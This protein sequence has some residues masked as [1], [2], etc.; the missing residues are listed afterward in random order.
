MRRVHRISLLLIGL[1]LSIGATGGAWAGDEGKIH[2]CAGAGRWFPAD[3]KELR[4]KVN[5]WLDAAQTP[6]VEG[7]LRALVAPHAGYEYSGPT[8]AYAYRLLR[9]QAF[10]RVIVLALS[11]S[12]PIQG[13][14]VLD[15]EGYQTPLGLVK[16]D[17]DV[18]R[19]LLKN[20]SFTTN[21]A[22][23]QS[24]HSDE[25][26][27]PFLQCALG[28][29]FK[30]VSILVGQASDED[31]EAAARSYETI[32]AAIRPWIDDQTLLVAS[33]DFTHYGEPYGYVPFRR[34]AKENLKALDGE[35]AWW[36]LRRDPAG[37]LDYL[38]R[39]GA[40]ICGQAPLTVLLKLLAPKDEGV[41]LH[42]DRSGS[43]DSAQQP[44]VGYMALAYVE[45][46]A[47]PAKGKS[48]PFAAPAWI[49]PAADRDELTSDECKTLL[50]L[51]R[52]SIA[53][54]LNHSDRLQGDRYEITPRLMAG[55]GA[56]VTLTIG[57]DLRG[58]IGSLVGELPLYKNVAR[59]AQEAAFG[60][61]R[62]PALSADELAKIHVEI[63][64]LLTPEGKVERVPFKKLESVDKIRMGKDG[65]MIRLD[66][67]SGLLLPQVPAEY[68][69]TRDEFLSHLCEKA[70][71]PDGS[72]KKAE[73]QRFDAQV[74]SE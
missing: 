22:A 16:V 21:E 12:T 64:A 42:Y 39:T 13:A 48:V 44:S 8:A 55:Q 11:H 67:Q 43:G 10:K 35:A 24:E 58:C 51:A 40:T 69:W 62:F 9:G 27:L 68:G 31:P 61:P 19:A 53:A 1:A 66:G 49:R 50:S 65:L 72:W 7:R 56:F 25:N 57:K 3:P 29:D 47:A 5:A 18:V 73:L 20:K 4:E 15:V 36:L 45:P 54:R 74:F 70:G 38:R 34:D 46:S 37:F 28:S 32:A 63:S 26:Q 52:D 41:F 59:M 23:H 33:S 2:P 30:L 60:D 71:L 14:S 17:R 6:P